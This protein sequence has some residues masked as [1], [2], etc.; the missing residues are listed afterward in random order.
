MQS[1]FQELFS[2]SF[3]KNYKININFFQDI[4]KPYEVPHYLNRSKYKNKLLSV[5]PNFYAK[6]KKENI[7]LITA[8]IPRYFCIFYTTFLWR[9]FGPLGDVL[10]G[11]RYRM[12]HVLLWNLTNNSFLYYNFKFQSNLSLI[13]KNYI[14]E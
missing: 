1:N 8:C 13:D 11:I 6:N 4:Q 2:F 5:K 10:R 9:Q 12:Y 3:Y 14:L 7:F